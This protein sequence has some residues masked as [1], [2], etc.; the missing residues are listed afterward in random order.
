[1]SRVPSPRIFATVGG[2]TFRT[3]EALRDYTVEMLNRYEPEQFASEKDRYFLLQLLARHFEAEDKIGPGILSFQRRVNLYHGKIEAAG[4]WFVRTDGT[5]VSFS[6][7]DCFRDR[8]IGDDEVFLR[9]IVSCCRAAVMEDVHR[10]KNEVFDGRRMTRCAATGAEISFSEAQVDHAGEWPFVRIVDEWLHERA[11]WLR[12][13]EIKSHEG[14]SGRVF[15]DPRVA[16]DFKE[17]H[18]QRAELRI[19]HKGQ[20]MGDGSRGYRM[21]FR[22]PGKAEA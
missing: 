2:L 1:V 17:F 8:P 18:D 9:R 12:Q 13:I 4:W 15:A 14:Q 19:V 11:P 21:R 20:N 10:L 6:I 7:Y 22:L 16:A 5:E 3:Q